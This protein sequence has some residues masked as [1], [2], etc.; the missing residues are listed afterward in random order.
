MRK[1]KIK[2]STENYEKEAG[3]SN[4]ESIKN[5]PFFMKNSEKSLKILLFLSWILP[6]YSLFFIYLAK[7]SL[8]EKEKGMLCKIMNMNFTVILI[9]FI[10]V[11][12]IQMLAFSKVPAAIMY[13]LIAVMLGIFFWAVVSHTVATIKWLKGKD[14][15][16]KIVAEFFKPW[17]NIR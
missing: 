16:Y 14:F 1:L 9:E 8:P 17:D 3:S 11:S 10:L 13:T 15:S 7:M 12:V 5:I 2:S 6:F 4:I